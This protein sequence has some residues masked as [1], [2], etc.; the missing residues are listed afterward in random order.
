MYFFNHHDDQDVV[1][2]RVSGNIQERACAIKF[3]NK[4]WF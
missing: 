1:S 4:S 3:S 2:E